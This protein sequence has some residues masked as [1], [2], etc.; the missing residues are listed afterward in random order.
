MSAVPFNG[1]PTENPTIITFA[2]KEENLMSGRL[3]PHM[4]KLALSCV[5]ILTDPRCR[6]LPEDIL[7][8]TAKFMKEVVMLN[9]AARLVLQPHES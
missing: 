8:L 7:I 6:E 5:T 1:D 2:M 3:D 9:E 4:S